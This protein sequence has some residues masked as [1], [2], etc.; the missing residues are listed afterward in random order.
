MIRWQ[1]LLEE[2]N[3]I[4]LADTHEHLLEEQSRMTHGNGWHAQDFSVFFAQYPE[5][6]L[7]SAG[8]ADQAADRILSKGT[9]P[10]E[11]WE[12][13]KPF[14]EKIRYTG[15]GMLVRES[16]NSLYGFDDL[17]DENW[18]ELDRLIKENCKA[19][20][21]PAI[22]KELANI[23]HMHV[24]SLEDITFQETAYPEWMHQD[25]SFLQLSVTLDIQ[26][27]EK[28]HDASVTDLKSFTNLIDQVFENYGHRA[29]AVK[30][31][32]A[33]LR[34][35]DFEIVTEEKAE[36]TFDAFAKSGFN[37]SHEE[38]KPLEDFLFHYCVSKATEASHPIK[39]HTGYYA[40]QGGMPLSRVGMNPADCAE[41]CRI[42]PEAK[43]VFMHS[44]YPYTSELISIAKHFRNAF[45]DMCWTWIIS[46][47]ASCR[48]LEEAIT[49]V[50]I[51]KLFLFGGDHC[52]V[53][54]IPGHARIARRGLA[55]SL[56]RLM[57]TGW[58]NKND[59]MRIARR[60]MLDNA[61]ELYDPERCRKN[62]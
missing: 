20:Y 51:N 16:I 25:I 40:G 46:P 3:S 28:R 61:Y 23:D 18:Q 49:T 50:P 48:F 53:E 54:L 33:Y 13:I 30:N 56:S 24:N 57:D 19:G 29:I 47:D 27:L 55:V 38:R 22:V 42:R 21:Y 4:P 17:T 12:L 15:Y 14:W 9:S 5:S 7:R 44:M 26:G 45:A 37:M 58:V 41:L 10:Q 2:I 35:L 11:K 62:N 36:R 8:M 1:D 32:G 60:V 34:R 59:A 6:D 52:Q 31:Q 39:L 43:F